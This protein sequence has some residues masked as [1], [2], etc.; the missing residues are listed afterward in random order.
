M[1]AAEAKKPEN[2]AKARNSARVKVASLASSPLIAA[3]F[4]DVKVRVRFPW[5][6]AEAGRPVDWN[7]SRS[8]G[9]VYGNAN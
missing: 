5:E 8:L 7:R 3:G 4:G 6:P 1:S 9:E 2:L